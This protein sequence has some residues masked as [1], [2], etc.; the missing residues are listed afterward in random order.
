MRRIAILIIHGFAGGIYDQ[1]DLANSLELINKFDVYSFTLPGH[2]KYV[3]NDIT[4]EDWIKTAEYHVERLIKN[5]YKKIYIVG[6]SMGGVISCSLALKYKE[7]KKIVLAAPAFEY[8]FSDHTIKGDKVSIKQGLCVLKRF[9]CIKE[10][11]SRMIKVPKKT[12]KEFRKLVD[13]NQDVINK[14]NIPVLI[15]HGTNDDIVPCN[16]SIKIFDKIPS[17]SKKL[18]VVKNLSHRVFK[19]V[20]QNEIISETVDFLNNKNKEMILKESI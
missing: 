6:H 5:G 3:L 17:L 20:K 1:E 8:L 9:N 12:I 13:T 19:D 11:L 7:I 14:L 2:D 10:V 16:S 4:K 15:I 18:L